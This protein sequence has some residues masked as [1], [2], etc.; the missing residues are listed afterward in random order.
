MEELKTAYGEEA[1]ERDDCSPDDGEYF[2]LQIAAALAESDV[3]ASSDV[4]DTPV[5]RKDGDKPNEHYDE[6]GDKPASCRFRDALKNCSYIE[7]DASCGEGWNREYGVSHISAPSPGENNFLDAFEYEGVGTPTFSRIPRPDHRVTYTERTKRNETSGN[8][9]L[10]ECGAKVCDEAGGIKDSWRWAGLPTLHKEKRDFKPWGESKWYSWE[11]FR[12]APSEGRGEGVF[13]Q[14]ETERGF[15]IPYLGQPLDI[16]GYRALKRSEQSIVYENTYDYVVYCDKSGSMEYVDGHPRRVRRGGVYLWPGGYVNQANRPG[17]VNAKIVRVTR[18]Q[19]DAMPQ[20]PRFG[21]KQLIEYSRIAILLMR[22]LLKDEEVL[23][24]YG[25]KK[26]DQYT[27]ECGFLYW[28]REH[29]DEVGVTHPDLFVEP[30]SDNN[31]DRVVGE[32]ELTCF[33]TPSSVF[34]M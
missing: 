9:T 15:L 17:E 29:K 18:K 26:A 14:A 13:M 1:T 30:L 31:N 7:M 28:W 21:K 5:L 33:S 20:Y 4:E 25:W 32:T 27:R 24:D 34:E 3:K 11:E 8:P 16:K 10:P 23:V 12:I 19:F 22:R 2:M 6:G